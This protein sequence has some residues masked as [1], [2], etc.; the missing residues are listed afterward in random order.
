MTVVEDIVEGINPTAP[1]YRTVEG[2]LQP[3][4]ILNLNAYSST[5]INSHVESVAA[6]FHNH[7]DCDAHTHHS[8]PHQ[9]SISSVKVDVPVIKSLQANLLDEWIRIVL[10]EH[11]LPEHSSDGMEVLRCKGVYS[12]DT[13]ECFMLQGVRNLYEIKQLTDEEKIGLPPIGKLVFIGKGL[14][15]YTGTSLLKF[16]ELHK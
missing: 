1:I 13:G 4:L 16:L 14:S 15:D 9:S 10:W 3:E 12:I 6:A 2:Q 11:R 8:L 5:S 7:D